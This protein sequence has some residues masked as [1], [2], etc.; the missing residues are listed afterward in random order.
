MDRIGASLTHYIR[1]ASSDVANGTT[2]VTQTYVIARW[3]WA[4]F[5]LIVLL[6]A[7]VFIIATMIS[8]MTKG[9][10]TWRSSALPSLVYTL[11][12]VTASTIASY[13]PRLAG[14]EKAADRFDMAMARDGIWK[15]EGTKGIRTERS[16]S[17]RM[18]AFWRIPRMN[19]FGHEKVAGSDQ[20]PFWKI[21]RRNPF[22]HE[23]VAVTDQY[24]GT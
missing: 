9:V 22:R 21:S 10:P 13:G 8:S 2:L 20:K 7:F 14:L 23:K 1:T 16:V 6:F 15:L 11:D 24:E 12:D 3:R 19:P 18:K 17:D 4:A 5:P